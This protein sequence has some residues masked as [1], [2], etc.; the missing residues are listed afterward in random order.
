MNP[1]LQYWVTPATIVL[2][3]LIVVVFTAWVSNR[4]MDAKIEAMRAE[5]KQGFA[6]LR[7]E[8]QQV[9]MEFASRFD[10]LDRRV[11]KIE[12]RLHLIQA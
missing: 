9:R 3:N 11:E 10:H 2:G 5:S 8:I 1:Q 7:L 6:E 12:E 4:W